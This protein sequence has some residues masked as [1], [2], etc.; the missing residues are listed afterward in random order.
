MLFTLDLELKTADNN[1]VPFST[2]DIDIKTTDNNTVLLYTLRPAN[3]GKR[4]Q[5]HLWKL[6]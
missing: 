6:L 3:S 4:H 5:C 2:L 1:E